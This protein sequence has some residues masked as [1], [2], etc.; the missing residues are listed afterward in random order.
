MELV[1]RINNRVNSQVNQGT[2]RIPL[3]YFNK[4]KTFLHSLPADTIRKP[5]QITTNTVKVN[6]SSMFYY[7]GCQYSVPPE[8][9]GKIVSLQVY[10][11]YIHVYCNTEFI[12]IHQISSKKINYISDHYAAIA[13]KCH[14]FRDEHI[15]DRAK[16]NLEIIGKVYDYE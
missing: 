7:K 16:E 1:T 6:H 10:D 13:R 9:V 12:T 2:G 8:Y 5:Y 11:G 4:E 15:M 14:I 3:M